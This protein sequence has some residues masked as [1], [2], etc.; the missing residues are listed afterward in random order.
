MEGEDLGEVA[1][2]GV[3]VFGTGADA[4]LNDIHLRTRRR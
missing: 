1:S 4:C 3:W 2:V